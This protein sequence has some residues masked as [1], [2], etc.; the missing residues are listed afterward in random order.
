[1]HAGVQE[2]SW[3]VGHGAGNARDGEEDVGD[4][5]SDVGDGESDIAAGTG[6]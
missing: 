4:G 3:Q 1:M 5:E 6:V 2:L